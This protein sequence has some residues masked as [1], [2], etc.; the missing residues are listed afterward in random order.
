MF[1]CWERCNWKDGCDPSIRRSC[2]RQRFND[3]WVILVK[4]ISICKEQTGFFFVYGLVIN[5]LQVNISFCRLTCFINFLERKIIAAHINIRY[6]PSI[7]RIWTWVLR[8]RLRWWEW[9]SEWD[10]LFIVC[11]LPLVLNSR[12]SSALEDL[13]TLTCKEHSEPIY[14]QGLFQF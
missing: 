2:S 1:S 12:T 10:R 3:S 6:C 14:M 9:Q 13:L 8:L 7:V 11:E 4:D 5:K